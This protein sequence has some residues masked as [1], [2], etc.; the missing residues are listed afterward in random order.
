MRKKLGH[1]RNSS[2]KPYYPFLRAVCHLKTEE[3]R[4]L[5]DQKFPNI[6]ISRSQFK[7]WLRDV[8]KET[9]RR[10]VTLREKYRE[11]FL[12]VC[13]LTMQ[14]AYAEFQALEPEL[15]LTWNQFRVRVKECEC[16]RITT[17]SPCSA[18]TGAGCIFLPMRT[19]TTN[20][21]VRCVVA[22][23]WSACTPT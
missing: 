15:N 1:D 18:S 14:E 2:K 7:Y 16:C 13:R 5:F 21:R 23:R 9:N 3:V 12:Q 17:P 10:P 19:V 6:D 20:F 8:R 4:K 11:S 22:I